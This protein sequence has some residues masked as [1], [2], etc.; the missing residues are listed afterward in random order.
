MRKQTASDSLM[1]RFARIGAAGSPTWVAELEA[2]EA[3]QTYLDRYPDAKFADEGF[4]RIAVA[5]QVDENF[6][7]GLL[8]KRSRMRMQELLP[9][10]L[11]MFS[12]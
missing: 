7:E 12:Q 9:L 1:P 3:F 4:F 11:R 5:H 8:P 10:L 2:I 6:G